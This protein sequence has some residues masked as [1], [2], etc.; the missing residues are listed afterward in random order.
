MQRGSSCQNYDVNHGRIF[1][2][3]IGVWFMSDLHNEFLED[4]SARTDPARFPTP[5]KADLL[6]LAGDIERADRV[7]KNARKQFPAIP[8]VL[9]AGNH[10]FYKSGSGQLG[11]INKMRAAARAD[12]E[13]TGRQTYFLENEVIELKIRGENLRVIGCTLW[14]DFEIKGDPIGH[15][16]YAGTAM[17]DYLYMKGNTPPD[18][19]P[20][21][22]SDTRDW[23]LRSRK[24]IGEELQK[25]FNG[26][27]IVVTHHLP[28]LRSVAS[29][30]DGDP[31]VPCYASDCTEI[32]SLGADLWIHGH[33]HESVDY[34]V[35]RTRVVA[36]PRGY[37]GR[38]VLLTPDNTQFDPS[39]V[40]EI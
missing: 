8:M 27:I 36:N 33:Q 17:N 6:V 22:P 38:D 25:P 23:H 29:R 13:L 9:I 19:N 34:V 26:K 15:A 12:R 3:T 35:G 40:V 7:V 11:T 32:L 39:R 1:E 21:R 28:S 30:Y 16:V 20:A 2:M 5:T 18:Y 37:P 14:T 31:L 4:N 24:F 10:E